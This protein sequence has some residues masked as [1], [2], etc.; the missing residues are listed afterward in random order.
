MIV[1]ANRRF[2]VIS[3]YIIDQN[4]TYRFMRTQVNESDCMRVG[5]AVFVTVAVLHTV[6]P[7][8]HPRPLQG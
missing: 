4:I 6:I 8:P 3:K 5:M 7:H 2:T 1:K